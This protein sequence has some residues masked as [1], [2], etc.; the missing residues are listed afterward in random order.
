MNATHINL[1]L[2]SFAQQKVLKQTIF[3]RMNLSK[4]ISINCS[5]SIEELPLAGDQCPELPS[6]ARWGLWPSESWD[7]LK[8]DDD[9]SWFSLMYPLLIP[10]GWTQGESNKKNS[11]LCIS[12][13]LWHIF[14]IGLS[15]I[16]AVRGF[17]SIITISLWD[18]L[19]QKQCVLCYLLS[20]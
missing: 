14:A 10:S 2:S 1:C 13:Y 19:F 7:V 6:L 16:L 8:N 17:I 11:R 12:R 18:G 9:E 3:R 4:L 20:C 5:V 15:E